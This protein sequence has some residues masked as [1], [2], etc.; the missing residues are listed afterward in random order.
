MD[1]MPGPAW[2]L[3]VACRAAIN[4]PGCQAFRGLGLAGSVSYSR[5]HNDSAGV[6]A[7]GHMVAY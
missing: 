2:A 3:L 1:A 4:S 5:G 6:W 7:G